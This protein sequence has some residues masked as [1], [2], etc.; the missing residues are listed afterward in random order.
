MSARFVTRFRPKIYRVHNF[1]AASHMKKVWKWIVEK[2]RSQTLSDLQSIQPRSQGLSSNRPLDERPWERGCST[3]PC[4]VA[5]LSCVADMSDTFRL[6][7]C[8]V[9]STNENA[10]WLRLLTLF[11]SG[12]GW[13]LCMKAR[14]LS[15]PVIF[16]VRWGCLVGSFCTF[17]NTST[18]AFEA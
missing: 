12:T 13:C 6:V 7:I 14:N 3:L 16:I 1:S 2:L 10:L 15:K 11:Y 17:W 9:V 5:V 4:S 18:A 8:V